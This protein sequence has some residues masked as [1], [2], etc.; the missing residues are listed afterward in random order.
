M[1][2][3]NAIIITT[4]LSDPV[5]QLGHNYETQMPFLRAYQNFNKYNIFS[6]FL[7]RIYNPLRS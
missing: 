5:A 1:L 4:I 2:L 3:I 6:Y 7:Y